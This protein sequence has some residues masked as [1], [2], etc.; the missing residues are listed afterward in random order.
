MQ[1]P[2]VLHEGLR[3]RKGLL[4]LDPGGQSARVRLFLSVA[5]MTVF[6]GPLSFAASA[7]IPAD[8]LQKTK[9]E[10]VLDESA[11]LGR[12]SSSVEQLR[13]AEYLMQDRDYFRAITTL[14]EV[15]FLND[16]PATRQYCLYEIA[17]AYQKSN[18]FRASIRYLSRLFNEP[19]VT[20]EFLNK[21]RIRLGLNYYGMRVFAQSQHAF[22]QA[23]PGDSTGIA[24]T[25]LALL[26]AERG[27]WITSSSY[28]GQAAAV[29]PDSDLGQ[30][31]RELEGKVLSGE[32]LSSR[33]P[34]LA[35]VMS[36]IL[37]GS[38]QFYCGHAFDG[39]QAFLYVGAFSLASYMT[40]RYDRDIND[41]Y[42][43]TYATLSAT[44]LFHSANII[45]AYRTAGY[46]NLRRREVFMDGVRINVFSVDF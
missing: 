16:T 13:F 5:L 19:E 42:V 25:Y 35:A 40:Y 21:G 20:P 8:E 9:D 36:A 44:A 46:Y 1:D 45:G 6:L 41:N 39:I 38:G 29:A 24:L 28:F 11:A 14:K 30:V 31:T 7:A 17:T 15:L 43:A 12:Y 18:R 33:S 26:E 34:T 2:S 32:Q 37:P 27:N 3:L 10:A 22:N 23:T 4:P